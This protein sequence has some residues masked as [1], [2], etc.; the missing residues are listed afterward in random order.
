MVKLRKLL[1]LS[2]LFSLLLYPLLSQSSSQ[3]TPSKEKRIV[4]TLTEAQQMLQG[5]QLSKTLLTEAQREV[6]LLNSD[7]SE[8]KNEVN[9]LMSD[10]QEQ[11]KALTEAKKRYEENLKKQ[12]LKTDIAAGV[13]GTTTTVS[14]VL[15]VVLLIV[16]L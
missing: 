16:L 9:Q 12:K 5:L 1:L 2:V 8:A 11:S 6:R 15:T 10:L 3:Q 13:A 14:I 4:L 7:L